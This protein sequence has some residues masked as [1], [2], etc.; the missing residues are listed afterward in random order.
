MSSTRGRGLAKMT[1]FSLSG[2]GGVLIMTGVLV[3]RGGD[4]GVAATTFLGVCSGLVGGE[5]VLVGCG[6]GDGLVCSS[7]GNVSRL[8]FFATGVVGTETAIG[9]SSRLA[10]SFCFEYCRMSS[11]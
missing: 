7:R 11:E 4:G 6:E 1:G 5:G 10:W 8:R 2:G 9:G 3:C